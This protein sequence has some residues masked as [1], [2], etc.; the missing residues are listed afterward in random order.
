VL[1][2]SSSFGANYFE[3]IV[4]IPGGETSRAWGVSA[5]GT[6]IVGDTGVGGVFPFRW[7]A[8]KTYLIPFPNGSIAMNTSTSG[9]I[10]VGKYATNP[11]QEQVFRYDFVTG[12]NLLLDS[13][14]GITTIDRVRCSDLGDAISFTGSGTA[15]TKGFYWRNGIGIPTTANELFGFSGATTHAAYG[16]SPGGSRITGT[17]AP[18]FGNNGAIG[19]YW[20]W[21]GSSFGIPVDFRG[22][23]QGLFQYP[24][25]HGYAV[26][27][28]GENYRY[29]VKAFYSA[30]STPHEAVIWTHSSSFKIIPKYQPGNEM[31]LQACSN[32]GKYYVGIEAVSGQNVS[33]Y[34]DD[35]MDTKSEF[36]AMF[37][38]PF[39]GSEFPNGYETESRI[40]VTDV[41][42]DGLTVVGY[43]TDLT[44][45]VQRAFVGYFGDPVAVEDYFSVH[46]APHQPASVSAPGVLRNDKRIGTATATLVTNAAHGS[47]TVNSNG[48]FSYQNDPW[49][50]G[51][52]SFT[53]KVTRGDGT[54]S[55][56]T[57]SL[58][59]GP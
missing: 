50:Y 16:I 7:C 23:G 9:D 58:A 27:G 20:G 13:I 11:S 30:G 2:A 59:V 19:C 28:I 32:D 12:T 1:A 54:E 47:V 3:L 8:G 38:N 4:T 26:G 33:W 39:P 24:A 29:L 25:S 44:P 17:S 45:T 36:K 55:I 41:S 57:V 34:F 22:N 18:S 6:V 56:S 14:T 5:D 42:S 49:F 35:T 51:K 53:Y 48:S 52:D 37:P 40:L 46:P 43:F 21:D 15:G 31:T 10:I